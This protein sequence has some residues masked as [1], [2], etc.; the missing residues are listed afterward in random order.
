[1]STVRICSDCNNSFSDDEEYFA[2]FLGLLLWG[3]RQPQSRVEKVLD[4]NWALQDKLNDCLAVEIFNGEPHV[5]LEPD[6]KR[7]RSVVAKN[8]VGH[9]F[10]ALGE[11]SRPSKVAVCALESLPTAIQNQLLGRSEEW[12]VVQEDV[13]RFQISTTE[14]RVIRSVIHEYL[15]T[16][17]V[18]SPTLEAYVATRNG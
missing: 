2:A 9:L 15:V 11:A 14:P 8:A 7:L 3:D 12:N 18:W 1:M 4:S 5:R 10:V 16:E 13:Y 17:A 6:E